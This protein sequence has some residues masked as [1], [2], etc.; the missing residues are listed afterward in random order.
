MQ[1]HNFDCFSVVKVKRETEE[2]RI[3]ILI[4]T[5]VAL[6]SQTSLCSDLNWLDG[7]VRKIMVSKASVLVLSRAD[8]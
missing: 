7:N 6:M 2:G 3:A 4:V 5:L 1:S 8:R